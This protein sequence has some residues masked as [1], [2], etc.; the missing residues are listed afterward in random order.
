M[1]VKGTINQMEE[2]GKAMK[3]FLLGM[4]LMVGVA[5]SALRKVEAAGVPFRVR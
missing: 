1:I 5:I 2:K 4:L 3:R